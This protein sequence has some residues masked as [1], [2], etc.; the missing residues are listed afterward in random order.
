MLIKDPNRRA[1]TR[2]QL[3]DENQRLENKRYDYKIFD[4]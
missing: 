3:K 4:I 2:A 1:E